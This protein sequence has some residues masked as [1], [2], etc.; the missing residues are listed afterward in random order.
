MDDTP[1]EVLTTEVELAV[2]PAARTTSALVAIRAAIADLDL[3]R[4]EL[5][6]AGDY[7]TLA[8]GGADVA[9]LIAD[10]GILLDAVRRD[11]A[12]LLDALPRKNR[13]AKPRV[14]VP[15]LGPVEVEGGSEW[16]QWR[17]E[18][19]LTR[20]VYGCLV[21]DDG[22]VIDRPPLDAAE[23]IV[24]V[25]TSCLPLTESLG[26]RKGSK[27]PDGTWSGLRGEGIDL[28]DYAVRTDKPRL[29]KLPKR[30]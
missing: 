6:A 14:E 20:L 9:T 28:E 16:K 15:G 25:L 26:W 3:Q 11:L 1:A 27:Q 17:S 2:H 22:E 23:A 5:V 7:V 13:R 8:L 4:R 24:A 18:D 30:Q 29:A 10:L 21:N 19:L 12:R